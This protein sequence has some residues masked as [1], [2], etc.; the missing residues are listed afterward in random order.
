[1]AALIITLLPGCVSRSSMEPLECTLANI[2]ID[3]M[4]LMETTLV[5]DIRIVNPNPDGLNFNGAAYKLYLGGGKVGRGLSAESFSVERLSTHLVK[6]RFHINNVAAI[7]RLQ[8]I[9]DEGVADYKLQTILY[10]EG[11]HGTKKYRSTYEGRLDLP[12]K[13]PGAVKID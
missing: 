13:R 8:Q 10:S 2:Q 4:T 9:Q 6:V 12:N 11:L 5:A 3:E 7:Y 1:M